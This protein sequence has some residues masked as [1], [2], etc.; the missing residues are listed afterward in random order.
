[1]ESIANIPVSPF[2]VLA[3]VPSQARITK[4]NTEIDYNHYG[5][6]PTS[7]IIHGAAIF[8]S[9]HSDAELL[10]IEQ[11]LQDFVRITLEDFRHS[12]CSVE[13][14]TGAWFT[15]RITKYEE[16]TAPRWHRDGRMFSCNEP[17]EIHS[18]YAV[19]LLGNTT[20]V[21]A[22]S[23][24]VTEVIGKFEPD[25]HELRV[26]R[27][28]KLVGEPLIPIDLG[29]IIR[30]TWGQKDSPVHSEPDRKGDRIFMS[31]LYGTRSEMKNMCKL[32]NED[33]I[34]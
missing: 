17:G 34:E 15:I 12:K 2:A 29:Q 30:F 33:Y 10:E 31:I 21:L 11:T 32:R 19:T 4:V 16:S 6:A 26:Q 23:S 9:Q 5:C 22:E 14:P 24:L 20:H 7:K 25:S 8:V 18:K 13:Q 28:V 1:M 27:A 3:A